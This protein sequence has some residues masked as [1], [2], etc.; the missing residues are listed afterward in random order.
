MA[1]R[2]IDPTPASEG[3]TGSI[4]GQPTLR[5]EIGGGAGVRLR[6]DFSALTRLRDAPPP[7]HANSLAAP[8]R[9]RREIHVIIITALAAVD[10]DGLT[11]WK[12]AQVK[13][14]YLA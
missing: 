1:R 7:A 4:R 10:Q 6:K 9:K 13:E 14:G 2:T 12:H 5:P 8:N 11:P 3:G